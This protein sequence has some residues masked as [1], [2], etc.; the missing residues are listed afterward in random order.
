MGKWKYRYLAP[1]GRITLIKTMFLSKLTH[2]FLSVPSPPTVLQEI[3]SLMFSFL[4]NNKPDKVKRNTICG[5]YLNGGLKM[6]NIFN[7]EKA[8]KINWIRKVIHQTKASWKLMKCNEDIS[9]SSIWHKYQLSKYPLFLVSW[10]NKGIR[11]VGDILHEDGSIIS[12]TELNSKYK[13]PTSG[14]WSPG[15]LAKMGPPRCESKGSFHTERR[16]HPPLH[17]Q[18]SSS[19]RTSDNQWLCKPPQ[20]PLPEGSFACPDSQKG[21]RDGSNFS[22]LFIVPKPNKKWPPILDLNAQN[23]FLSVKTFKME[24]PETTR[25]MADIAG[26]QRCLF[27]HS[28]T[29]PIQEIPPFSLPKPDLPIP[30]SSLWPLNSS[31]GVHLCGQR[32]QVDGSS[33]GYKDPP[34]PRQLV[35]SSPH[36][37]ILP[38]G[39]PDPPRPL[40]GVGLGSEPLKI[41]VGPQTGIRVCGLPVRPIQRTG[42][43]DPEPLGVNPTERGFS[44]IQ[45]DLPSQEVYVSD[46]PS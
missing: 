32:G 21:G 15:I 14:R 37:R 24:T 9:Q 16:V 12:H 42:Q 17:S 46:R 25:G 11:L 33:S 27:P 36:Q 28:N 22:I 39:H 13:C 38:P 18:T 31:Y 4:W 34:V 29:L 44:A 35:D 43:T 7:F 40:P 41:G 20:E 19:E 3:N 45:S 10:Y 2:L 5:D 6:I 30:G 1:F 8:L 23:K 26:F